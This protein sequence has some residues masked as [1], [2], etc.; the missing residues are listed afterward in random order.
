[1]FSNY[2][3]LT[4]CLFDKIVQLRNSIC[5]NIKQHDLGEYFPKKYVEDVCD[6]LKEH[7]DDVQVVPCFNFMSFFLGIIHGCMRDIY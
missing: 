2:I 5:Q 6:V 3:T 1:M 7:I 4:P